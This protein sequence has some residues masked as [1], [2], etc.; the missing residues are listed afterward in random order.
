MN[1]NKKGMSLAEILIASAVTFLVL[2]V[3]F[4]LWSIAETAWY[5]ERARAKTL[6]ELEIAMERIKKELRSST[7]D[8]MFF[9][10]EDASVYEA[11]SFPIAVDNDGDGFIELDNN[12][13]PDEPT[14]DTIIWDRTVI[15]HVF[16]TGTSMDLRRTIFDPRS[17]LNDTQRQSQIDSVIANGAAIGSTPNNAN[18][19]T[20]TIFSKEV[21]SEQDAILLQIAPKLR[22]FDGYSAALDRS[23]NV[24][25]GSIPLA[26]EYHTISFKTTGQNTAS[27]SFGL[28]V[29][30]FRITPSGSDREGEDYTFLKHPDNSV[31]VSATSG[32]TT[33]REDMSSYGSWSGD[34]HLEYE[35]NGVDDYITLR[36][37]NDAWRESNFDSGTSDLVVAELSARTGVFDNLIASSDGIV[38]LEGGGSVWFASDQ[39]GAVVQTIDVIPP[40]G[41]STIRNVI[42]GGFIGEDGRLIRV[43][44]AAGSTGPLT[45]SHAFICKRKEAQDPSEAQD[46]E[47]PSSSITFSGGASVVIAAD[48]SVWSDWIDLGAN[49]DKSNDYFIS[50]H[51]PQPNGTQHSLA[52]WEDASG[53]GHSYTR[54]GGDFAGTLIWAAAGTEDTNVYVLEEIEASY[55]DSGNFTSQIYDTGIANPGFATMTWDIT[56]N[57]Y[58]DA[59]CILRARSSDDKDSLLADSDW[60]DEVA[61]NTFSAVQ[62]SAG[63]SAIGTGRYVQFNADFISTGTDPGEQTADQYDMSS[64]LKAVA[65]YWPGATTACA[66]SG[67]FTMKPSYG[68]FTVE[69]DG[70]PLT[71]GFEVKLELAEEIFGTLVERTLTTEVEP[72]NTGL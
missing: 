51:L 29:D 71:K 38:R 39:T 47:A 62:G 20:R 16:N 65:I 7:G 5:G 1:S 10:P 17:S 25:F 45:I 28:G 27:S 15:Y 58:P 18:A 48:D 2:S 30:L 54:T 61:V 63:I 19:S 70:Q 34:H 31:G 66:L 72:R 13:T 46:G 21:L 64:I 43:K 6:M 26:G 42:S 49:I 53:L 67:Y 22:E 52:Y 56:R 32:D 59:N 33:T 55:V 11:V 68:I 23:S 41:G 60:S 50:I 40:A 36:F 12:N 69:I 3:S 35:A 8:L 44:F 9:Y 14:D 57:N 4:T 37:Y 24:S